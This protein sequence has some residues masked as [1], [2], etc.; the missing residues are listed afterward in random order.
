MTMTIWPSFAAKDATRT[1]SPR[2]RGSSPWRGTLSDLQRRLTPPLLEG[3]ARPDL[4]DR[5]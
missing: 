3:V 2:V 4:L 5:C 1:L